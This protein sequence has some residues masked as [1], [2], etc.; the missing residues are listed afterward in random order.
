ML[1]KRKSSWE[2][3]VKDAPLEEIYV[4]EIEI[5]IDSNLCIN[6]LIILSLPTSFDFGS[7]EL[8]KTENRGSL[9]YIWLFIPRT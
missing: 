1:K 3:L 4:C 2:M 5:L 9:T 7:A 8:W 6:S